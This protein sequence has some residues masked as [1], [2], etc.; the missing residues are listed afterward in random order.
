LEMLELVGVISDSG[1]GDPHFAVRCI[2]L[3]K[4]SPG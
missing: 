4:G 1:L 3:T 2:S